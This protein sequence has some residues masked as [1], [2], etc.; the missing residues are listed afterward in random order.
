MTTP[1]RVIKSLTVT[2]AILT[3]SSIAEA[4]HAA[5]NAGTT[6]ALG[7]RVILTT[8]VHK[9]YES[10]Q[11]G[12]VGKAPETE[13][14]WW[15]E[16][17]PTNR[18]KCLDL[19]ST[20]QT[21]IDAADYYEFTPAQAV[22]AVALINIS[23]I[24]T[25]CVR[26]TDPSFGVVYDTGV[27]SLASVPSESSWYAWFFEPRTEQTQLVFSDLPSYP[28][29]V[30]RIDVTSSGTAYIGAL[31]FGTQRSIGMGVQQGVRLG[32]TDYSRKERN[33]WGDTV[34][35][36]RAFSKRVSLSMLIDN[37]ELD[38]TFNLLTDLRATPCLWIGTNLYGAL[39]VFG[40]YANFDIGITYARYSDCSIDLES[41]T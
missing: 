12:N 37:A 18:W 17:S 6:Y 8:G 36:Q 1:L 40:F 19:S 9:I 38:N 26:M 13:P 31:A 22:N 2:D 20:T 11:A 10:I 24:L 30:L 5:Y 15:V 32:L 27:Q 33:S 25:I 7:A 41:L 34:L 28:N 14:N 4:D 39:S 29:A 21:V 16:V 3:G 35:V 23:G